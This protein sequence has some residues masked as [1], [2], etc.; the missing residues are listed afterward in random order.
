VYFSWVIINLLTSFKFVGSR[1]NS[2]MLSDI[3]SLIDSTGPTDKELDKL[4]PVQ[5]Y[6]PGDL[7]YSFVERST[8]VK[9]MK[10]LL[11]VLQYRKIMSKYRS[12]KEGLY[13]DLEE[14]FIARIHML[15]PSS[16][17]YF[18]FSI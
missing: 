8:D 15:E 18:I 5:D 2:K 17:M 9:Y 12:G 16:S 3:K 13:P 1:I 11:N 4:A 6:D 14:K 10:Q 7:D